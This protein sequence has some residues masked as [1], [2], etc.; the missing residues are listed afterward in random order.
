VYAIAFSPDGKI[1]ATGAADRTTKLWNFPSA[2]LLRTL[3]GHTGTVYSIAF[4]GAGSELATAGGDNCVSCWNLK[5]TRLGWSEKC[6]D[7]LYAVAFVRDSAVCGGVAPQLSRHPGSRCQRISD[8]QGIYSLAVSSSTVL[9]AAGTGD[10]GI[11]FWDPTSNRQHW[12][13]GHHNDV[14]W[15]VTFS[16]DG[17][18]LA[19]A[20]YDRKVIVFDVQTRNPIFTITDHTAAVYSVS[21]NP[22][23]NLLRTVG[24]DGKI[25]VWDAETGAPIKVIEART[26]W[27]LDAA[28]SPDGTKVAI[29]GEDRMVRVYD[30]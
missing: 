14:V 27:G 22:G 30:L 12:L 15:C 4:T 17:R 5:D 13:T 19:T 2:E 6:P 11:L 18:R 20:G 3:M 10:G 9:V 28:W 26:E 8:H 21:Y 7:A 24:R 16:P 25:A 1:L 29:A 23:A